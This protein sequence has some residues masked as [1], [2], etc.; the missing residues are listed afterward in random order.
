[1]TYLKKRDE[2]K[3]QWIKKDS[4]FSLLLF[5]IIIRQ[6]FLHH[7]FYS[8]LFISQDKELVQLNNVTQR[9]FEDKEIFLDFFIYIYNC[10]NKTRLPENIIY[11]MLKQA[12]DI[13]IELIEGSLLPKINRINKM[14][15][16]KYIKYFADEV[17]DKIGYKKIYNQENPYDNVKWKRLNNIVNTSSSS[18]NNNNNDISN[19]SKIT[20]KEKEFDLNSDF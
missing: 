11:E 9:I 14:D 3:K 5:Y 2:F 8:F 16:I 13:E 19:N 10:L 18:S 1:L 17:L 20:N 15:L 6:I 7:I 12:L 4:E